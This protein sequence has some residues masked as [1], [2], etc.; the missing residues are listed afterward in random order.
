MAQAAQT[1]AS[2]ATYTAHAAAATTHN[3]PHP[4]RGVARRSETVGA[5]LVSHPTEVSA[6]PGAVSSRVQFVATRRDDILEETECHVFRVEEGGAGE[7]Y[8]E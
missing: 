5:I 1:T 7:G 3:P 8:L 4:L 2:A 6:R